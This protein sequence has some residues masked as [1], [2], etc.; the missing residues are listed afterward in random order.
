MEFCSSQ[1]RSLTSVGLLDAAPVQDTQ[2][3]ALFLHVPS[4]R[5][6]SSLRSPQWYP[7]AVLAP[8]LVEPRLD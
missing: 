5:W 2:V 6:W 7:V 1:S 4:Y 8:M 3:R